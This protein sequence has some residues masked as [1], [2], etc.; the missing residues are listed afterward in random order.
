MVENNFYDP[1]KPL[2]RDKF[3]PKIMYAITSSQRL[4]FVVDGEGATSVRPLPRR[5]PV[6]A[7]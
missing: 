5:R 6:L 7:V 3:K 1:P 2:H 4:A